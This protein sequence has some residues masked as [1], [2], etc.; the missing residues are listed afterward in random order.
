[1]R[2]IHLLLIFVLCLGVTL[3]HDTGHDD[4]DGAE[5]DAATVSLD[6]VP[7][8]QGAVRAILEA[9]CVGCHS[10]GQI[11][12]FAPL[13]DVDLVLDAAQDINWHTR[14][15]YMPPWMPSGL[16]LPL[17]GD[18]RLTDSDI[19]VIAAWANGGAPMGDEAYY[20][21]PEIALSRVDVRADLTLQLDEAYT[22]DGEKLDDYRCFAFP[23]AINT[24][25]F[26]TGFE[27]RPDI[28][29]MA[30]HAI[31]Y[32]VGEA[33]ARA[34]ERRDGEDG[35]PGWS[36][37]GDTGLRTPS[38]SLGGWAPGGS[39]MR[40]PAGMG[41]R[42]EPSQQII[43][44]LHYNLNSARQP[45]RSQVVLEL[46]PA[47]AELE[48]L[49]YI[50]LVAPVEIPCPSGVDGPQCRR[51]NALERVA[52]LYGS[53]NRYFPDWILWECGQSLADYADNSGERALGSCDI[54]SP[55][56][57]TLYAVSGHMHELGS[58]FRLTL[59]PDSEAPLPLLDIPR[60]DFNWQDEFVLAEPLEVK[61]GDSLR[62]ECEW[63]NTLS[64][65]PRYVVW[66]EGTSDEMCFGT[67]LAA[68][69]G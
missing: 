30:H 62:M 68:A 36:C 27:F 55:A 34:I 12:A 49:F 22:P 50:S 58:S 11:A 5:S 18:R 29:E 42:I 48:E 59:N 56:S 24:P 65:E 21:P 52:D 60:W 69:G 7:T 13:N 39:P 46:A 16:G 40:F 41:F 1:M 14:N 47:D 54:E 28:A 25:R 15:R 8:Y 61:P 64:D 63:D 53:E 4:D 66:G 67:V 26:V 20:T 32:L 9:N 38:D 3:A 51:E 43:L 33:A 17:K 37:Y 10:D 23:L 44:Q 6:S 35:K 57:L 2:L 19:A 45:D 31:F